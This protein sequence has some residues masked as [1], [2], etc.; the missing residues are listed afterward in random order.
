MQKK[1]SL[2][3]YKSLDSTNKKIKRLIKMKKKSGNFCVS[4]IT[5][6]NGYGRRNTIWHSYNGNVHLSIFLRPDCLI[7]QVNQLSFLTSISINQTLKQFKNR[8]KIQYKWPNDMLLNERKFAG[9]LLETSLNSNKKINWVI[10]GVGVNLKKYPQLKKEMFKATS[11]HK[12]NILIDRDNFIKDFLEIFFKNF[13]KWKKSGFKFI[14][15]DWL[16]NVYKKRGII[17]VKKGN[18]Y[19]KGK[20]INLLTNGSIKIKSNKKMKEIYFGD[21]II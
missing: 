2:L 13:E 8:N 5:Q 9:I 12:E 15:K 19:I 14:K 16:S 17:I 20:L 1:Y 6:T 10:I 11:L 18:Q 3:N 7:K 4:S 21:Q